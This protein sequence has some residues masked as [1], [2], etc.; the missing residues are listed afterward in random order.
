MGLAPITPILSIIDM[1]KTAVYNQTGEKVSETDLNPVVFG[2]A[3]IDV[4]LVHFALR[5]QRNNARA[6]I[7]HTKNRGE[8]SGGGKK[9]W[10]QKGT[11]RA[12]VGSIR[13]PIWRKGG[14]TFGPRSDRNFSLKINRSAVR[15]ALATVLSDK[16]KTNRLAIIEDFPSVAK[17]KDLANKLS[18]LAEKAGLCR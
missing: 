4:N 14:V 17:T 8:V 16:L 15:L 2:L 5:V 12:R 6:A 3:K 13:S 9:P 7:A 1:A 10:K 18:Q 11:G